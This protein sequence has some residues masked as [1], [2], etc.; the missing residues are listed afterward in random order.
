MAA[1]PRGAPLFSLPIAYTCHV[2]PTHSEAVKEAA[3]A[4]AGK[5]IH[6]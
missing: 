5:P 1:L 2:H 6:V 3:M 4:I